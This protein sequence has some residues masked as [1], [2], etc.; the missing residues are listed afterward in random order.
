MTRPYSV[1]LALAATA[2][3]LACGLLDAG[4]QD[5][6]RAALQQF[7][8]SA[9]EYLALRRQVERQLP[10]LEMSQEAGKI[11]G[12]IERLAAAMRDA[13]LE[14]V[15]GAMFTADVRVAFRTRIRHQ[16]T[17][18]PGLIAD[19]LNEMSDEAEIWISPV[20]NERFSWRTAAATPPCMLAALPELPEPLQYRFVGRDL[21]LIDSDLSLIIDVLPDALW[22]P[23]TSD[24]M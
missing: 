18:H 8:D 13:R 5:V 6:D 23:T 12:A 10:P 21:V 11:H 7:R 1:R 19:V 4:Q 24:D 2:V 15:A 3:V 20:V 16:L 17:S 22:L 14:A 9:A